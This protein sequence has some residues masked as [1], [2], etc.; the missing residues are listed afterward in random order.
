MPYIYKN[1]RQLWSEEDFEKLV[2]PVENPGEINYVLSSICAAYIKR[3][4]LKYSQINDV[5][6]ALECVKLELY[7]R[8][9]SQYE[10]IKV[11]ENGDI[12][13]YEDIL[14]DL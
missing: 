11:V 3:K 10:D 4:G 1:K 9:A 14:S 12:Q 2:K 6:G 8:L 7:R 13:G 5:I